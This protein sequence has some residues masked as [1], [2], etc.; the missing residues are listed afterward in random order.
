MG[1]RLS[2][3]IWELVTLP[4]SWLPGMDS[5][6]L[7]LRP[8]PETHTVAFYFNPSEKHDYLL[9]IYSI[10]RVCVGISTIHLALFFFKFLKYYI[11][12]YI[13][14]STGLNMYSFIGLVQELHTINHLMVISQMCLLSDSKLLILH[15]N[16]RS[17]LSHVHI[18][19]EE[20]SETNYLIMSQREKLND[21]SVDKPNELCSKHMLSHAS[22]SSICLSNRG[23][24][25]FYTA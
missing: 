4:P 2:S 1:I 12:Y 20:G 21:K 17:K 24:S 3:T 15:G 7:T 14:Y 10:C 22:H 18:R 16:K 25:G 19:K 5:L 13:C 9:N 8:V 6:S 11:Q 23:H